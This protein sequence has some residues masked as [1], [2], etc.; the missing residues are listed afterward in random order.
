MSAAG[1][2][3]MSGARKAARMVHA[4]DDAMI[5]TEFE[6]L[7]RREDDLS[8]KAGAVLG[9]AGL[10]IAATLVLLA[11]EP[12]TALHAR[13]GELEAIWAAAS[14]VGLFLGAAAALLA[15]GMSRVYDFSDAEALLDRLDRRF[16]ARD[17]LWR[18]ACTFTLL[19]SL[20]AG[21]AYALVLAPS[22]FSSGG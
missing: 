17:G 3:S 21:G 13:P 11:A 7:G 6:M 15:I 12:E 22:A 5:R 1:T 18:L 19:G 10:M 2:R 16:R 4:H 20:A 14:L 9:F 8:V